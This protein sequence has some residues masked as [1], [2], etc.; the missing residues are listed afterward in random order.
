MVH[1]GVGLFGMMHALEVCEDDRL[2]LAL[3]LVFSCS[4]RL[5]EMLGL[6]AGM[7][8]ICPTNAGVKF[9]F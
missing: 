2:K 9:F 1:L 4:L 6:A 5:G 3:N 7:D 8:P